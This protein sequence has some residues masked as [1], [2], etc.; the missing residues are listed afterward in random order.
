MNRRLLSLLA[1][2]TVVA[3]RAHAVQAYSSQT[4]TSQVFGIA[5]VCLIVLVAIWAFF[6]KPKPAQIQET[7]HRATAAI[8]E[9]GEPP[10]QRVK[11]LSDARDAVPVPISRTMPEGTAAVATNANMTNAHDLMGSQESLEHAQKLLAEGRI[12]ESLAIFGQLADGTEMPSEGHYGVA[13]IQ[14]KK[15]DLDS[16]GAGFRRVLKLD[17]N[18]ANAAYYLG[19]ISERDGQQDIARAY[20]ERAL[21]HNPEHAGALQKLGDR[22]SLEQPAGKGV[23]SAPTTPPETKPNAPNVPPDAGLGASVPAPP[24]HAGYIRATAERVH[25]SPTAVEYSV[26]STPK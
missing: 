15:G 23:S 18:H 7:S 13:F 19:V 25:R 5:I 3:L 17:P 10:E 20:Y 26:C 24:P 4:G 2:V 21:T 9:K 8:S 14:F 11:P 12:N 6:A 16:A 1:V 22:A